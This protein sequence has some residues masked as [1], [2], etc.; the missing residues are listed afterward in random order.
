MESLRNLFNKYG[1]DK[2][3]NGYTPVYQSLFQGI[4]HNHIKMLEI[5]IG[6][7][8]PGKPSSMVGYGL[9]GYKPG[10][11]L[12][13]WRDFFQNG[14]IHGMDIQPDTQFKE[15]RIKT[16]LVDSIGDY[17]DDWINTSFDKYDIILDDGLHSAEA[18][19]KTVWKGER[20]GKPG[21]G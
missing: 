4:R 7:M 16:F 6:T 10:G 3:R 1:S 2:D 13:A 8:I 18:Q 11:S 12:R 20:R 21:G 15:D 14:E 17:D 19:F 9:E 5:G